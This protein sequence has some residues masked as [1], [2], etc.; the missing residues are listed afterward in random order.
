MNDRNA[1]DKKATTTYRDLTGEKRTMN[2]SNALDER[3][4]QQA[5]KK[6]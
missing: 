4:Q 1:S 6:R 2:N 5:I 3:K